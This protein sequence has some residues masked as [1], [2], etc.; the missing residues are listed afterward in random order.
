[1]TSLPQGKRS[2]LQNLGMQSRHNKAY[3]RFVTGLYERMIPQPEEAPSGTQTLEELLNKY[4]FDLEIH[5]QIKADLK[6]GRIGLSQNRLP[7][8]SIIED[9]EG[10][11]ISMFD[12]KIPDEYYKTGLDALKNG[13]LAIVTLAGG[14]GVLADQGCQLLDGEAVN[15]PGF[16][17]ERVSATSAHVDGQRLQHRRGEQ[18][19]QRGA[20]TSAVVIRDGVR[21]LLGQL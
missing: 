9:V 15:V 21:G 6:S 5:Q 11:E 4:G 18:G 17:A 3:S 12:G 1:M 7:V 16:D 14:A 13:K 2:E 20:G 19:A 10:G 8:S